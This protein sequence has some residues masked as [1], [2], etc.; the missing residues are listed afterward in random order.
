MTHNRPLFL[1]PL[2]LFCTSIVGGLT[3]LA[4]QL[5]AEVFVLRLPF[6]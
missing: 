4:T 6:H 1:L 5:P 3:V 2:A